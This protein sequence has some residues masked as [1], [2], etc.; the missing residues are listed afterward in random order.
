MGASTC[1]EMA[2]PERSFLDRLQEGALVGRDAVEFRHWDNKD[3]DAVRATPAREGPEMLCIQANRGGSP[4]HAGDRERVGAGVRAPLD[5]AK[6]MRVKAPLLLTD[7]L[8][9]DRGVVQGF[10]ALMAEGKR[11]NALLAC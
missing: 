10:P 7:E 6:D 8:A 5:K 11:R 9:Q 3:V 2:S 4:I 1:A